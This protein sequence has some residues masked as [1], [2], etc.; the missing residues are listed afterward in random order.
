MKYDAIIIGG[1]ITGLSIAYRFIDSYKKILLI[2]S[3][4]RLGG[5]VNTI[6][7]SN[8]LTYEAGAEEYLKITI[9]P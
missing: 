1:G 2:E 8:G 4:G 6:K 9:K 3:T 7:D 5:R